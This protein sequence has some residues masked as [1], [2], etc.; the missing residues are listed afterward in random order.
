[1]RLPVKAIF[2]K[3]KKREPITALTVYDYAWA[4]ILDE[5]GI[6][7]LL[8][9]DS[10]GMVI[11]GYDST[12]P[13]TMRDML[14]HTRAVSRAVHRSLLVADMPYGSYDSPER[15]Y[16]NARRLIQ[17]GGADAVK[18]EGG[19]R[20]RRQVEKLI[21]AGIPV[22]GHVGMTPQTATQLGGYRVQGRVA[23]EAAQILDDAKLLD[24][25]G[26]FALV[27]EC[28]P[29]AL[30]KKVT[31]AVGC[32]T[33]GIGAGPHTDGQI[34]VLHDMLGLTGKVRPR[35][36]RQ[37]A[38]MEEMIRKA[39]CAYRDDVKARAYPTKEESY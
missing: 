4:R 14:H 22:M 35:F 2:D 1:M 33:I 26:V 5:E 20:I 18:L 10:L 36:V 31:R 16:R 23:C 8:V 7:I 28:V 11:L 19:R 29:A 21:A 9:G 15:A 24:R 32:P 3:K 39:V 25:L 6:D 27:L 12:V 30:G 38:A 13:V 34:L 37:Y 17:E